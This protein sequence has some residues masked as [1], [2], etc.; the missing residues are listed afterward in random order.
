MCLSVGFFFE[1]Y[2]CFTGFLQ[3]M[4]LDLPPILEYFLPQSFCLPP[5]SL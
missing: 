2:L 1:Q 4:I 3:F 5:S